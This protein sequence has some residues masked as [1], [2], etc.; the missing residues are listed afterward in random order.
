[1]S[2]TPEKDLEFLPPRAAA[3][4]RV[5][6]K[7]TYLAQKIILMFFIA[8]FIWAHFSQLH[9]VTKG[10]GKIISSTHNQ[11]ISNLEGG[12]IKEI[13]VRDNQIV[14]PG[15]ILIRL[16][17][18]ISQA[19]YYQGLENYYRFLASAERL[20]AQI[21]NQQAF[22]PSPDL[23]MNAPN[24][25]KE[26]S[27][28][29]ASNL[30][31]K[32]NDLNIARK[33]YEMKRQE[34][35]EIKEKMNEVKEQYEYASEQVK[36]IT[37]LAKNKIYSQMDYLKLMR[38]YSDQ[39]A[40][41]RVLKVNLKRLS[42]AV[43]QAKDRLDQVLIRY[44]TDDLQELRDIEGRLAEV[45]G[46]K[47]ADQDRV[48]RSEIRSPITGTIRD[49]KVR[50]IGGVVQPGEALLDIVPLNDTLI[51]EAQ[52]APSDV[53]FIR[54]GMTATIKVTAYDFST[55]GGLEATVEHISADTITDKREQTFY[56]VLLQTKSNVLAKKGRLYAIMPGMQVEVDILTGQKSV[57]NYFLKPFLRAIDNSMTER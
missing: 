40:Q 8:F 49:I 45:R 9:E 41:L 34:M 51:V 21:N 19:K 12:I 17:T 23:L 26:E 3:F 36:I 42:V 38:D 15:Q 22:A 2:E 52:I 56:R 54:P 24:L 7:K 46:A 14:S 6:H 29:F 1:M 57:L 35:N 16:D 11:T 4:Y 47:T 25:A 30:L 13:L 39:K 44:R 55:Y 53:A 18:T 5:G 20:Q 10:T 43:K 48:A 33:D 32:Q 50:T 27:V 37:P 28:R 31:K